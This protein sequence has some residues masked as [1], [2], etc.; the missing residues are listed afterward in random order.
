MQEMPDNFQVNTIESIEEIE[1]I[2]HIWEEMQA[3]ESHPKV[4]ADID[5]YL[6]AIKSTKEQIQPH[7]ILVKQNDITVSMLIGYIHKNTLNCKLGRKPVFKHSLR[8]LSVIYGGI[9]GTPSEKIMNSIFGVLFKYLRC[10]EIDVIH[11]NHLDIN[12]EL[13]QAARHKSFALCRS[14]FTK[15]EI[16]RSMSVPQNIEKFLHNCSKKQ[17]QNLKRYVRK[18]EK[19]FPGQVKMVTYSNETEIEQAI[20]IASYISSQTYQR[21]FHGGINDDSITRKM[22]NNA[23]KKGWLRMHI[24]YIKDEPCAFGYRLKYR[25]TY[26]AEAIGYL[27]KWENF[28]VGH[29][30]FYKVMEKICDD[31]TV[32]RLDFGFG[33]GYHKQWGKTNSRKEVSIYIFAPRFYPILVNLVFSLTA[34]ITL[35]V[36]YCVT[37]LGIFNSVQQYRR[38]KTWTKK[39]KKLQIYDALQRQRYP[40]RRV[41]QK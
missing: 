16:H 9:L 29:V 32:N 26:F 1:S 17:R 30:L 39:N 11:F 7:I 8:T 14:Y 27:P 23:A 19:K 13:Y 37:R 38:K 5:R 20:T 10:G 41:Q 34:G 15:V 36:Q 3:K 4:N 18:L 25:G 24:L 22:F 2:R 33:D 28:G 40:D 31:P 6:S 21:A 12:S 35:L